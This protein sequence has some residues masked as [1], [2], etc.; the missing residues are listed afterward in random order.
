MII[1]HFPASFDVDQTITHYTTSLQALRVFSQSRGIFTIGKSKKDV[2]AFVSNLLLS[3][4]DY[5]ELR[6]IAQG[7]EA[8]PSISGFTLRNRQF[9]VDQDGLVDDL[10]QLKKEIDR[11]RDE[12]S[13]KGANIPKISIPIKN[14]DGTIDARFEYQRAIP[15]RVELLQFTKSEVDFL[16]SQIEDGMWQ[17]VCYPNSNQDVT[18]LEKTIQ[19]M[20]GKSYETNSL[21][22]DDLPHDR[23]IQF[24]D[25]LLDHYRTGKEWIAEHA[26]EITIRSTQD[27]TSTRT[28][29]LDEE[30]AELFTESEQE[31][32]NRSDL[33]SI[34][35]AILQG[36]NLRTNSFVKDCERLGFYFL[37]M[38]LALNNA[39]T[40]D[41]IQIRIRFK[42]SPK[43]FEVVLVSMG[44]KT[45]MGEQ[46]SVFSRDKQWDILRE[47]WAT[48]HHVWQEVNQGLLPP[49]KLQPSFADMP[50]G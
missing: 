3:H 46:P 23:R 20:G 18:E 50:H 47:F 4:R 37:S 39:K 30:E 35:Q 9:A 17:L 1:K 6:S 15:G 22:L 11:N 7:S 41:T 34:N 13:Q 2:S 33:L 49:S 31:E 8:A 28:L 12:L 42:L 40:S 24:Y 21:S 5:G 44:E 26:T 32:I 36:R 25:S 14:R 10:V 27:N 45:D 29:I 43:M 48:S 16:V 38:T 19:R